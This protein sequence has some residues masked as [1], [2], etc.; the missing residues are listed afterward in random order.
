MRGVPS[1]VWA[2]GWDAEACV[3]S[4]PLAGRWMTE[5]VGVAG[6]RE[7]WRTAAVK[8]VNANCGSVASRAAVVGGPSARCARSG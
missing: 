6:K 8:P 5:E 1:V 4:L 2:N 7:Q 3:A